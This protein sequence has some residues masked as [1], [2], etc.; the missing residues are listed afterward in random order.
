M[1]H[2]IAF[3]LIMAVL[4]VGWAARLGLSQEQQKQDSAVDTS[5]IVQ[6]LNQIMA[7][8]QQILQEFNEIKQELAIIK[9]RASRR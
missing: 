9:V 7:T 8:Q 3:I 4:M 5:E 1:K 2:K 6:K